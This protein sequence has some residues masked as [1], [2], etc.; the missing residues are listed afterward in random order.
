MTLGLE[1]SLWA[2]RMIRFAE[3][4]A[5]WDGTATELYQHVGGRVLNSLRPH[6]NP[7]SMSQEL[8]RMSGALREVGVDMEWYRESDSHRTRKIAV[9]AV[10]AVQNGDSA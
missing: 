10:H 4:N 8:K 1:H 6:T 3:K 5:P 7:A 9:R 2:E